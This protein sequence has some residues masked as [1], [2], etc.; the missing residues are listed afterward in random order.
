MNTQYVSYLRIVRYL[1]YLTRDRWMS[2]LG[3]LD[4]TL[5]IS[6]VTF[7]QPFAKLSPVHDEILTPGYVAIH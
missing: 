1:S 2:D 4:R 6:T 3:Q 7:S 5:F